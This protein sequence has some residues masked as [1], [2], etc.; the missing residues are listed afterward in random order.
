MR[1]PSRSKEDIVA[2]ILN[3][4]SS[5]VK[6]THI[7]Y[8]VGLSYTQLKIYLPMMQA[9]EM[10]VKTEDEMWLA[11]VRGREY[12]RVYLQM[13]QIIGKEADEEKSTSRYV[14]AEQRRHSSAK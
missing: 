5:P 12:L 9:K 14:A 3:L 2:E 11:T 4:A 13:N 6:Q 7:M 8:R 10:I 1:P